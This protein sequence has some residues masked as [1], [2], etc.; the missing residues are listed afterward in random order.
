M[1]AH[2]GLLAIFVGVAEIRG[3]TVRL[4]KCW[5]ASEEYHHGFIDCL[6]KHFAALLENSLTF[7]PT[8]LDLK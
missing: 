7:D 2:M 3:R 5:D 4:G 6:R 1:R 8:V